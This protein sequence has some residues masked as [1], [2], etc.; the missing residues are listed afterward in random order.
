MLRPTLKA[1]EEAER[2][3]KKADADKSRKLVG[4][5][6][7]GG[8]GKPGPL[9]RDE[10]APRN[11]NAGGSATRKNAR[12]SAATRAASERARGREARPE[13]ARDEKRAPTQ[14]RGEALAE[15]RKR[16]EQ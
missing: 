1:A 15:E 9:A 5:A 13:R 3:R 4:G 2:L 14:M 10:H 16:N 6:R 8:K 7:G 11:G 12:P